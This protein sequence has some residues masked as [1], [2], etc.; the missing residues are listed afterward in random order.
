MGPRQ[1]L[2]A[3]GPKFLEAAEQE[4][5]P[6]SESTV[7]PKVPDGSSTEK[8]HFPLF[9]LPFHSPHGTLLTFLDCTLAPIVC[10]ITE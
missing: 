8:G 10:A 9:E 3:P 7:P 6:L 5:L 2:P 4:N 1:K